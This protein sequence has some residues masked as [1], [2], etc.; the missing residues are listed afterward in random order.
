VSSGTLICE[1]MVRI[2][3]TT[4]AALTKVLGGFPSLSRQMIKKYFSLAAISSFQI[5]RNLLFNNH[6]AMFL[7]VALGNDSVVK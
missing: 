5:L 2:S 1:V 4:P 7:Y 3:A 6:R